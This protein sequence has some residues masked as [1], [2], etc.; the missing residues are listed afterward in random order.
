[1]KSEKKQT[2]ALKK[3]LKSAWYWQNK[4]DFLLEKIKR[5]RSQAEKMTTSFQ[6]VPVIGGFD[7]HRQAVI[8]EIIDTQH[9]YER[10]VHECKKRLAELRYFI[11]LLEDYQ[12]MLV[13]EMRYLHYE[14]W[15]DIAYK[16]NYSEQMIYKIHGRALLHLLEVHK[17]IITA[18]GFALYPVKKGDL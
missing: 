15:Q 5:L 4:K 13:L 3:Y 2:E 6:D 1:M 11:S 18:S 9:Q 17:K 10:A 14:N 7:D 12:E 8:V 16:L